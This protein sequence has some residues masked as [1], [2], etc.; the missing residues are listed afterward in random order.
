[1]PFTN[2]F[3]A[4]KKDKI[5]KNNS[6]FAFWAIAESLSKWQSDGHI[7]GR[8]SRKLGKKQNGLLSSLRIACYGYY[9]QFGVNCL[10]AAS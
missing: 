5:V 10:T 9:H 4:Q 8:L 2:P 7:F 3:L 1:M 6:L